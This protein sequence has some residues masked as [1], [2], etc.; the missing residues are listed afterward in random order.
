MIADRV[1]KD[2]S[3]YPKRMAEALQGET[4]PLVQRFKRVRDSNLP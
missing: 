3:L 4:E 1:L 2:G